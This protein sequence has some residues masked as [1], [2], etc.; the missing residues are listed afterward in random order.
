M[1]AQK[2]SLSESVGILVVF[3]SLDLIISY[4]I[5]PSFGLSLCEHVFK[6]DPIVL[7]K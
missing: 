6:R 1:I 7:S 5:A 3:I 2:C 4:C